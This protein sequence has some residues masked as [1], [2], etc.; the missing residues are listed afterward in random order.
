MHQYKNKPTPEQLNQYI[1]KL[2]HILSAHSMSITM[3][4]QEQPLVMEHYINGHHTG[5]TSFWL[6]WIEVSTPIVKNLKL[7]LYGW[8]MPEN[9]THQRMWHDAADLQNAFYQKLGLIPGPV[10][11]TDPYWKLWD[12]LN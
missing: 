7:D 5:T 8:G 1:E 3:V 9:L 6:D 11:G 2:E 12:H 4:L 10:K